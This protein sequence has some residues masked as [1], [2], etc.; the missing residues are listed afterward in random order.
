MTNRILIFYLVF[1]LS[2]ISGQT[3]QDQ[4]MECNKTGCK[5]LDPYY[6]D[7]ATIT[8]DGDCKDGKANGFGKAIKYQKGEYESTFEGN[9]VNGIREGNGKFKHITGSTLECPFINGQGIGHGTYTYD[10]GNKYEGDILNYRAHGTG[11]FYYANGSKFEGFFV[12]DNPYTGKFTNY[13]GKIKY[14]Q[15][16]KP[17]EKIKENNSNYQPNWNEVVTEYFDEKW[18][19]CEPKNASFYRRVTY[20]SENKPKGSVKDYFITGQ[21][22]SEVTFIFLDYDDEGKNFL[23][24]EATWYYKNGK[25]QEKRYYM[26]NKIN[27]KNTT[28]YESGQKRSECNYEIG[29]WNGYYYQ[30]YQSGS[31]YIKAYYEKGILFDNKYVEFDENGFGSIVYKETFQR[32]KDYWQ[33]KDEHSEASIDFENNNVMFD[34]RGIGTV[35]RGVYIPF[36]QEGSYSIEEIIDRKAIEKTNG[37]G[38]SFGFK[39]WDN[40]YSFLISG[41]GEYK[42]YGKYEGVNIIIK[43]WTYSS[44]INPD[45]GSHRNLLKILKLSDSFIFSINGT[46]VDKEPSKTLRG[47]Y[48]GLMIGGKGKVILESLTIHEFIENSNSSTTDENTKGSTNDGGWLGNGSGFFIN[49]KGYIV[50]NYHVVKDASDIQVEFFQKGIRK[51]YQAKVIVS[52]KVND[53]SIIKISDPSFKPFPKLPYSFSTNTKDVGTSV[54]TLGYPMALGIMGEEVKFTDGKISAK[55]GYKGDITVYQISVAVQPGNSGG[56][57]FDNAGNIVGIVSSGLNK[58]IT[59]NVNYAI[60]SNYLKSL[61]ESM[62]E[63]ISLPNDLTISSKILTEQVKII[64]DYIPII[65][66]K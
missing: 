59:E 53:L 1:N 47:N 4:W 21:L 31:L 61:I 35:S 20:E 56:P 11:I 22:Q 8:W 42:I 24:G 58:E 23:E 2:N 10:D 25:I 40:Y 55:S 26:N 14:I 46:V 41:N 52:D 15:E 43:D 9:Y 50:T 30:W 33:Y 7:G 13:D 27:G 12:S 19:R 5:L 51:S 65:K 28:W 32:N 34:N 62:P 18:K 64:S 16:R 36:N 29:R 66:I 44:S 37:V 54:F 45:K 38:L 17:V 6:S 49:E 63:K 48:S 60:K 57:L 3:L 39:D